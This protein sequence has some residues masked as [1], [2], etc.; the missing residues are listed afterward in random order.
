[1]STHKL[2]KLGDNMLQGDDV[3][4]VCIMEYPD[5]QNPSIHMLTRPMS[6]GYMEA[7]MRASRKKREVRK[8]DKRIKEAFQPLFNIN[9]SFTDIDM[10]EFWEGFRQR[11]GGE[12]V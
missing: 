1:M 9:K 8:E 2:A 3:Q 11:H 10:I 7:R 5:G 12:E 6:R 4:R